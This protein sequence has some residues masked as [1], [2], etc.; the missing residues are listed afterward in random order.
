MAKKIAIISPSYRPRRSGIDTVIDMRLRNL[1]KLNHKVLFFCPDYSRSKDMYP[2]FEKYTGEV[3]PNVQAVN[4]PSMRFFLQPRARIP[5][6]FLGFDFDEKL[7]AFDPEVILLEE[8]VALA[9]CLLSLPGMRYAKK[10]DIPVSGFHHTKYLK[11]AED[12]FCF[13]P[14]LPLFKKFVYPWIFNGLDKTLV[15]SSSV[16]D[17]L[18]ALGIKNIIYD[19]LLGVDPALFSPQRKTELDLLKGKE[20][21][22]KI[23]F[24][25]RLSPDKDLNLLI[26]CFKSINQMRKDVCFVIVGSGPLD[27][28]VD[29]NIQGLE[30]VRSYEIPQEELARIYASCDIFVTASRT[31]TFGLTVLEAMSSGLPVVA[32]NEGGVTETVIDQVTGFLYKPLD[33]QDFI[34]K[35]NHL[36]ENPELRIK[37]GKAGRERA[38]E[39]SW[40]NATK[41][42]VKHLTK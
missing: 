1:S 16:R 6:P 18:Q 24:T 38:L 27:D 5:Y 20:N 12:Y 23:F 33:R 9:L 8:P 42:L 29:K 2:D 15:A 7:A 3:Y 34:N 30:I 37:M 17:D 32:P 21:K 41:N 40:E 19:K 35:I 31:E 26:D 36:C 11:Y 10:H 28:Y 22:I 39:Y 25:G 13:R 4:F 14:L